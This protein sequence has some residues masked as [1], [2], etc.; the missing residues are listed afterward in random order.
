MKIQTL[1]DLRELTGF[2]SGADLQDML[3]M[4][5][6]KMSPSGNDEISAADLS[7]NDTGKEA[8]LLLSSPWVGYKLTITGTSIS[9]GAYTVSKIYR[10]MVYLKNEGDGRNLEVSESTL[11]S[12]IGNGIAEY[13]GRDSTDTQEGR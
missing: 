7:N 1:Y 13:S 10:G 6:G 3:Y 9:D 12:L 11:Q 4:L 8:L 5:V 2:V